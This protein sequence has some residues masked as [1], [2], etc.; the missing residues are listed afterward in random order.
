MPEPPKHKVTRRGKYSKPTGYAGAEAGKDEKYRSMERDKIKQKW[1][2][3]K[4][5]GGIGGVSK[6]PKDWE[7]QFTTYYEQMMKARAKNKGQ[8]KAVSKA[9]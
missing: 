3:S 7:K 8:K 6:R 2:A 4:G 5:W 1:L 9:E